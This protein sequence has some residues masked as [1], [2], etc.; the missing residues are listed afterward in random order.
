[1]KKVKLL[2]LLAIIALACNPKP[3]EDIVIE[4]DL[5]LKNLKI[6][7]KISDVLFEFNQENLKNKT[8]E[9]MNNLTFESRLLLNENPKATNVIYNLTIK[10]N[11]VYIDNVS[12]INVNNKKI[13]KSVKYHSKIEPDLDLLF[14]GARCPKGFSQ[15]GSCSN[16]SGE[17]QECVGGY[18]AGYFS[19]NISGVGDCATVQVNVGYFNTRVYGQ[20]G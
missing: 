4:P 7:L 5:N 14:N 13:I 15:V 17:T 9:K 19:E 1:M 10:N 20:T 8:V 6:D 3:E 2:L 18:L 16:V 11:K 12:L